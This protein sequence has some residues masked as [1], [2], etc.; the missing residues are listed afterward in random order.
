MIEFLSTLQY[1]GFL[2]FF[3]LSEVRSV[4]GT[5]SGSATVCI[6]YI[7]SGFFIRDFPSLLIFLS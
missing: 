5:F 1:P 3:Q 4:P 2:P 7:T 6:P